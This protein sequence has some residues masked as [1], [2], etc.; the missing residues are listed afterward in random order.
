MLGQV[1]LITRL[2]SLIWNP[3]AACRVLISFFDFVKVQYGPILSLDIFSDNRLKK[4][5]YLK[6]KL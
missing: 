6:N 2:A 4:F 5:R 3:H 1:K